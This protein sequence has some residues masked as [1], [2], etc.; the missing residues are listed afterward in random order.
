MNST[1]GLEANSDLIRSTTSITVTPH[2]PI[3]PAKAPF[4]SCQRTRP[5]VRR[6]SASVAISAHCSCALI[7]VQSAISAPVRQHPIQNP[8]PSRT[9][10]FTQGEFGRVGAVKS[11][12]GIIVRRAARRPR[13]ELWGVLAYS[14][15]PGSAVAPP[16]A[17][18]Q[19]AGDL[20]Q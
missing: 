13:I 9:Q 11:A 1:T 10:T 15:N 6:R 17:E 8:A 14:S 19:L 20:K 7:P 16:L 5:G 3:R 12:G 18:Q 2:I 4:P